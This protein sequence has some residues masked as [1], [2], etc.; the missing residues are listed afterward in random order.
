MNDDEPKKRGR[1]PVTDGTNKVMVTFRVSPDM[2]N[3]LDECA[4][5]GAVKAEIFDLALEIAKDL[6]DYGI[7]VAIEPLNPMRFVDGQLQQRMLDIGA[8]MESRERNT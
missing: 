5:K 6:I 1:R 7:K 4:A 3:W 8:R 2:K